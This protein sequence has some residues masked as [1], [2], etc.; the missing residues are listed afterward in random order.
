MQEKRL[1]GLNLIVLM[2]E[3]SSLQGKLL[4]L[5][6]LCC[7]LYTILEFMITNDSGQAHFSSIID[8]PPFLFFGPETPARTGSLG[9]TIFIYA[10]LVCSPWIITANH[11]KTACKD[12]VCLQ[13]IKPD[14]CVTP[15]QSSIEKINATSR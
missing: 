11:R 2:I 8:R 10:G 12:N 1:K 15:I 7:T 5:S 3:V 6:Y 13:G 4:S 9:G 14:R